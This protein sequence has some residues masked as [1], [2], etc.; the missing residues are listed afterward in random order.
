MGL[1][2]KHEMLLREIHHA[3][4]SF[5]NAQ[6]RE[7][8]EGMRGLIAA[9]HPDFCDCVERILWMKTADDASEGGAA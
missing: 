4:L 5:T 2:Q 6:K 1:P 3:R 9:D 8:V 7:F